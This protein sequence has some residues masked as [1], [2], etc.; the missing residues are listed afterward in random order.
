MSMQSINNFCE[1]LRQ[2]VFNCKICKGSKK[3][4][5][6]MLLLRGNDET[7][8]FLNK[9]KVFMLDLAGVKLI[10]FTVA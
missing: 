2:S 1:D 3:E 5:F 8:T 7:S 10:F 4:R 9:Y 6:K